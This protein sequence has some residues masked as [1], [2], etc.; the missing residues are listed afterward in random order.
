LTLSDQQTG[1]G[2]LWTAGELLGLLAML[3]VL[4]RW[5]A[6]EEREAI[7]EDARDTAARAAYP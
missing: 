3:V 4:V 1:A 7:R 5:M 2:I 6:A